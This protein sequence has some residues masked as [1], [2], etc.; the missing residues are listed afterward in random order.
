M[1]NGKLGSIMTTANAIVEP[2]AVPA[3]GIRYA[4]PTAKLVNLGNTD[5][6][7][8]V[9][10]SVSPTPGEVDTVDI[11]TIAANGGT[12]ILS[13]ACMSPGEKFLVWCDTSRVVVRVEGIEE[14]A[15]S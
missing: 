11:A 1:A 10:F 15:V 14:A 13:C 6:N 9:Y 3:V 8:K 4:V 5:A 7:V 2:Y 12:L